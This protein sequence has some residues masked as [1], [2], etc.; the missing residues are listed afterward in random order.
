MKKT[1]PILRII[2]KTPPGRKGTGE[3]QPPKKSTLIR[4]HMNTIAA[5][6][7]IMKRR[8]GVDEYST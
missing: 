2:Q 6:S 3:S 7:P 8:N 1:A 4:A 5:Y